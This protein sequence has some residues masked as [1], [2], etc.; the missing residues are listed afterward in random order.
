MKPKQPKKTTYIR[1]YYLHNKIKKAGLRLKLEK[2]HKTINV[3]TVQVPE[4]K[5]NKYVEE[6]QKDHN[7]GVQLINP[8]FDH[9]NN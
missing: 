3:D 7:Y 6:L 9:E 2:C 1:K 5:K 8:L 4:V